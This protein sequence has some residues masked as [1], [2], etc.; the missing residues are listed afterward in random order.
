MKVL[1]ADDDNGAR[2]VARAAVQQLGHECMVASDGDMAWRIFEAYQPDVLVTDWMMPGLDG[3]QLCR[4][5]RSAEQDRY[6]YIVLLTSRS[7]QD[8]VLSGIEAG[9]DDYVVKPLDPF[10]LRARLVVA[11]RVTSLHLELAGYRAQL[12]EQARTDPLTKLRNRLMLSEDLELL[13]GRSE[14]YGHAYSLALCDIDLFKNYNDIYG[15]QAG[16]RALQSVAAALTGIGRHGDSIYRYGG[17]EFLIVLPH[18]AAA[19]A[20]K[21]VERLRTAV[22]G[23]AVEH[24]ASA[25]GVLT[26]S[27]GVSTFV[28]GGGMG[29]EE[30]LR[31]ADLALYEAK[32]AGRNRVSVATA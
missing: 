11:Q 13:H 15:H 25:V 29:S 17:E 31:N 16:D 2:L 9:A 18:Q 23:L 22:Q 27:A 20:G 12:A 14:R 3:P 8:E 28:P 30:L 24:S 19:A 4:A 32:S 7:R 1:I 21:A 26:V 5:V 6:T 10:A